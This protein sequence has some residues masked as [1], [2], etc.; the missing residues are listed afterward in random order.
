MRSYQEQSRYRIR[1]TRGIAVRRLAVRLLLAAVGVGMFSIGCCPRGG[2]VDRNLGDVLSE[3]PVRSDEFK[4]LGRRLLQQRRSDSQALIAFLKSARNDAEVS[5]ID[6]GRAIFYLGE[7][8]D[9]RALDVLTDWL[10]YTSGWTTGEGSAVADYPAV[11]ALVRMGPSLEVV[12]KMRRVI[13][14]DDSLLRR[15]L[16]GEV[17]GNIEG[18]LGFVWLAQWLQDYPAEEAD[19]RRARSAFEELMKRYESDWKGAGIVK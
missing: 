9:P 19:K 16:A 4:L 10:E 2:P 7:L 15:T 6:I 3:R 5:K 18:S 1:P 17:I 13:C 8:G 11:A 12:A 14:S